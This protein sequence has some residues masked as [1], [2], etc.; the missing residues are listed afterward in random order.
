[1][2]TGQDSKTLGHHGS[3][4]VQYLYQGRLHSVQQGAKAKLTIKNGNK[5]KNR[6][7]PKLTILSIAR[8]TCTLIF[9]ISPIKISKLSKVP[10][11]AHYSTANVHVPVRF[12]FLCLQF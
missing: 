7:L 4:S 2:E 3:R 8:T 9:V 11:P 12:Y 6:D 5:K 1:M 10:G